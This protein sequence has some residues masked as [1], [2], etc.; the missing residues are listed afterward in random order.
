M[1][2]RVIQL[3]LRQ[4]GASRNVLCFGYGQVGIP[5]SFV[6]LVPIQEPSSALHSNKCVETL[7]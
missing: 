7:L 5:L 3:Q 6:E 2:E 1:V 4:E